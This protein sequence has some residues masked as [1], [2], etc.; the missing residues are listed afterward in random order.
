MTGAL[1]DAQAGAIGGT[2]G[3]G[4]INGDIEAATLGNIQTT[5][6]GSWRA[7]GDLVPL[8]HAFLLSIIYASSVL[9]GFMVLFAGYSKGFAMMKEYFIGLATFESIKVAFVLANNAVLFYSQKNAIG[10][11]A[12]PDITNAISNPASIPY[13]GQ[14]LEYLANMSGMAGALGLAT[15]LF[16]PG[17]IF[18]GKV[19]SAM[20]ILGNV[21]GMVQN[22]SANDVAGDIG[23][24]KALDMA[25]NDSRMRSE[26]SKMGIHVGANSDVGA[27]YAEMQA[28]IDKMGNNMAA[29]GTYSR[30]GARNRYGGV[31]TQALQAGG[32]LMGTGIQASSSSAGAIQSMGAAS[33]ATSFA[34][35]MAS[36]EAQKGA[37]L[38]SPDGRLTSFGSGMITGKAEM[39]T[40]QDVLGYKAQ[41]DSGMLDKNNKV[42]SDGETAL[43]ANAYDATKSSLVK[44]LKT[45]GL[46]KNG[47]SFTDKDGKSYSGSYEDIV[48]A[49]AEK[50]IQTRVGQ[51]LGA[52]AN[53]ALGS[54]MYQTNALA[55][56]MSQTQSAFAAIQAKGG[57]AK[58]VDTDVAAAKL[59]VRESQAA[60]ESKLSTLGGKGKTLEEQVDSVASKARDIAGTA[61][62][63]QTDE[64]IGSMKGTK[65]ELKMHGDKG[66]QDAAQSSVQSATESAL[67]AIR[68]A[69]GINALASQAGIKAQSD[70]TALAAS[71]HTAGGGAGYIGMNKTLAIGNTAGQLAEI[72]EAGHKFGSYARYK[73]TSARGQVDMAKAVF[74]GET[75]VDPLTH[76]SARDAKTGKYNP[77]YMKSITNQKADDATANLQGSNALGKDA[78]KAENQQLKEKTNAQDSD[79]IKAGLAYVDKNG[80]VQ[81]TTDTARAIAH[82][83][84][85]G[86]DMFGMK[87]G[88]LLVGNDLMKVSAQTYANS[89]GSAFSNITAVTMGTALTANSLNNGLNVQDKSAGEKAEMAG[90][91]SKAAGFG[92][93]WTHHGAANLAQN[94]G[95]QDSQTANNTANI[96]TDTLAT[97]IG[98]Y[99]LDKATAN[100]VTGIKAKAND[101]TFIDKD[102]ES[103]YT[104]NKENGKYEKKTTFS[105]KPEDIKEKD[106]NFVDK[107][108]KGGYS[109]NEETGMY[110]RT[111]VKSIPESGL[112]KKGW[113]A[114]NYQKAKETAWNLKDKLAGASSDEPNHETSHNGNTNTDH[115]IN[116]NKA[117]HVN[118]SSKM[119]NYNA[120]EKSAQ[121]GKNK[122]YEMADN[123]KG[124]TG[125]VAKYGMKALG[126]AGSLYESYE[127]ATKAVDRHNKGDNTG[128]AMEV[129]KSST[130]LGA[131][132]L[133]FEGGAT[134]GAIAG[135]AFG[136]GAAVASPVLS[137]IGGIAGAG[138]GA[139]GAMMQ[140]LANNPVNVHMQSSPAQMYFNYKIINE[141]KQAVAI[142]GRKYTDDCT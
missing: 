131:A 129:A 27:V 119:H 25:H 108:G 70:S 58:S 10:Q 134:A 60:L 23:N 141:Y 93:S 80:N 20:G 54:N 61:S 45:A 74:D 88:A 101:G 1:A 40:K 89:D 36:F 8:A 109:F 76:K 16:I 112:Q 68:G 83:K 12:N 91:V 51:G 29:V 125:T 30:G 75:A 132:S 127:G 128:A 85:K 53:I 107:E 106:G 111:S 115:S 17:I 33:G 57:V 46:I 11:L 35:S 92:A 94:P 38:V 126:V 5:G 4:T 28:G 139:Y 43:Y 50:G 62:R 116:Q 104:K 69:G 86:A 118:S 64:S 15:M 105:A 110:D 32:A 55:S 24:K 77:E 97:T 2:P 121:G 71:I 78:A 130:I 137:F 136:P 73:A 133:G 21:G 14:H 67:G 102:G 72:D 117:N 49:E 114:G 79:L 84:M 34:T 44:G 122:F 31:E 100:N 87:G 81:D 13:V 66:F 47:A 99:T 6:L 22:K 48:N 52:A 39:A 103:G 140:S 123:L 135:L 19:A 9:M 63:K 138:L 7:M 124:S 120:S 82:G 18:G 95:G 56:E 65:H 96:V 90:S 3:L 142:G 98:A 42:S 41:Q 37:G 59:G 113:V 26:L